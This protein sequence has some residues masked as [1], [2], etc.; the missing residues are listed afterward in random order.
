MEK[1]AKVIEP[2]HAAAGFI[3]SPLRGGLTPL[4][5][6]D[7]IALTPNPTKPLPPDS[8]PL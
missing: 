7:N 6:L 4:G 5:S 1:E 8:Q 2:Q 3:G